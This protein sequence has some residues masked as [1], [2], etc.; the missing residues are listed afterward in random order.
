[1][2]MIML[3][4]REVYIRTL[5]MELLVRFFIIFTIYDDISISKLKSSNVEN[6]T[7]HIKLFINYLSRN[8]YKH[9]RLNKN[10]IFTF[11]TKK[12][13]FLFS[14]FLFQRRNRSRLI[15]VF[16][17]ESN[18]VHQDE[19]LSI[20]L[21]FHFKIKT[22]FNP[23]PRDIPKKESST[24]NHHHRQYRKQQQR[25]RSRRAISNYSFKKKIPFSLPFQFS[26]TKK[27]TFPYLFQ[28]R[29]H[30]PPINH[31]R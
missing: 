13:S 2:L 27:S 6:F 1:M 31:R 21:L 16:S 3:F 11:K 24:I 9:S 5:K 18:N 20:L 25:S 4:Y 8:N 19:Y 10:S 12:F 17:I 15:N 30:H 22:K 29:N 26:E 14:I 28:R 23:Y 7:Y